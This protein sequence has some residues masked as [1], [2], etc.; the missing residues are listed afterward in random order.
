LE[1]IPSTGDDPLLLSGVPKASESTSEK[2]AED[3]FPEKWPAGVD[4]PLLPPIPSPIA[5][6]RLVLAC[7][8]ANITC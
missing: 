1:L 7:S 5:P 6:A 2:F 4:L 8:F 3:M